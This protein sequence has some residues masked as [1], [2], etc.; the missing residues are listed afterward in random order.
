MTGQGVGEE[1]RGEYVCLRIIKIMIGMGVE[2]GGW[3]L[4][5]KKKRRKKKSRQVNGQGNKRTKTKRATERGQI[6]RAHV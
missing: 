4:K 2:A 5:G 1:E 3:I 6:G